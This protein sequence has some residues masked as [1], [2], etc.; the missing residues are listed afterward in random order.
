M[1]ETAMIL[2]AGR[3]ARMRPLTDTT[4]KPLLP[5]CGRPLLAWHL[6]KLAEAGFRRVVVNGAWL[7]E[8]IEAFLQQLD[9]AL[10]IHFSPEPP[11]G[12]ETA[13]GIIQ[14]LPWLGDEPFAVING[15]VFSHYDYARFSPPDGLA[16]L[17]LVPSPVHNAGG[18]FGLEAGRV[19]PHGPWTFSGLSVLTPQLFAGL[20]PGFRPLAPVLR[21]AMAQ[22]A[23]SGEVFEGLWSDVGTPQRLH[24]LEKALGCA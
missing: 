12:L 21:C 13:G 10:E 24:A 18:D 4:P 2:A 22:G 5:V 1:L 23:V 14:A 16:H 17:V 9:T 11:G 8:Q 19:T 7:R 3:G 15:D 6:H 20:T